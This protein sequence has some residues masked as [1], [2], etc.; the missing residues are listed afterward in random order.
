M[1]DERPWR[2][3]RSNALKGIHITAITRALITRPQSGDVFK[4]KP[5][6]A[7]ETCPIITFIIDGGER[8]EHSTFWFCGKAKE[9]RLGVSLQCYPPP[10]MVREHYLISADMV[11]F[12]GESLFLSRHLPFNTCLIVPIDWWV[13]VRPSADAKV[14]LESFC[15][16]AGARMLL[17][18]SPY[19]LCWMSW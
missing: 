7:D 15:S 6:R 18:F 8:R 2:L 12:S 13:R 11:F 19:L 4:I 9:T 17:F 3:L 5:G 14:S 10:P 1:I 16:Q